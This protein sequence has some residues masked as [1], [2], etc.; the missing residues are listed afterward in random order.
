M[1]QPIDAIVNGLTQANALILEAME[2]K[3]IISA[4]LTKVILDGLD[5][6]RKNLISNG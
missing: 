2:P 6:A 1:E 4:D 5:N 3:G